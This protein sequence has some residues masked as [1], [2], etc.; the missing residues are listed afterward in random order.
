MGVEQQQQW[1][2]WQQHKNELWCGMGYSKT[3]C[4]S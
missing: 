3:E 2:Q 1:Q 4:H